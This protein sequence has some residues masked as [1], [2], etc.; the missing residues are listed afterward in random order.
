MASRRFR[1]TGYSA[2]S[3]HAREAGQESLGGP[4]RHAGFTLDGTENMPNFT[5]S[6]A[7]NHMR[8]TLTALLDPH[9]KPEHVSALWE[10]FGGFCA[11]CGRKLNRGKREGHRDHLVSH[12]EGGANT[13]YN[14]VLACAMCNG[15]EKRETDWKAFLRT[16]ASSPELREQRKAAIDA[17]R[18]KGRG[19]A[20]LSPVARTK[21]ETII[22]TALAHF[23]EAVEQVRA[24]RAVPSNKS[25]R[26]PEGHS[27]LR[28]PLPSLTRSPLR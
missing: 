24:L 1:C 2:K 21:A 9:P 26:T 17:W 3:V 25:T 22:A 19:L 5:P 4:Q 8:R 14:S 6:T 27:A 23:D 16:K 12:A 20:P 18:R 7:K 15:N 28:A 13:I 11:Y 10:H